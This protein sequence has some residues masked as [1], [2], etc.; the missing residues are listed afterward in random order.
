MP[1][2]RDLLHAQRFGLDYGPTAILADIELTLKAGEVLALIGASGSGKSALLRALLGLSP[3]S[4]QTRGSVRI[5]DAQGVLCETRDVARLRGATLGLVP[6]DPQTALSAHRTVAQHL[7]EVLVTHGSSGHRSHAEQATALLTAVGLSPTLLTRYPHAL[8]GGQGQRVLVALALAGDPSIL[9]ADEP[10]SALD[11]VATVELLT[12]LQAQARHH[13]RGVLIVSH[14]L[15]ATARVADRVA[16]LAGGR[17]VEVGETDA[18]L[19]RPQ[20]PL[21]AALVAAR[22]PLTPP[23]P[24]RLAEAPRPM[25]CERIAT[26][27][28]FAQSCVRA[29]PVCAQTPPAWADHDA[30]RVTCHRPMSAP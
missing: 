7:E 10:T 19:T 15:A 13:R 26:R 27:C 23:R 28:A 20:H 2:D 12:L 9:L 16:V 1:T 11:P 25:P 30:R 22:P 5:A 18:V 29:Q 17:L 14:D 21:T 8:S 6:Q 24:A 3:P 4:A